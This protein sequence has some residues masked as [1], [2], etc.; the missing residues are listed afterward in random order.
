M[1]LQKLISRLNLGYVN[2]NITTKNFPKQK[3]D[4]KKISIFEILL[5]ALFL[6]GIYFCVT[7]G[8]VVSGFSIVC[9]YFYSLWLLLRDGKNRKE[10]K[11]FNFEKIIASK[12]VIL[13]MSKTGYRPA[14]L[15]ELLV[16]AIKNWNGKDWIIA[17]GQ[18]MFDHGDCHRYVA[19]LNCYE[20]RRLSLYGFNLGWSIFSNFLAVKK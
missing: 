12:D 15:R 1:K 13:E 18:T 7:A 8:D 16:W 2:E 19:V 17:L 11:L 5:T 4:K 9:F 3:E 10:Y 6:L 20:N 14:T